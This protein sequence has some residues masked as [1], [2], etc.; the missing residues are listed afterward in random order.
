MT[1]YEPSK[2]DQ[3]TIFEV[4]AVVAFVVSRVGILSLGEIVAE[5]RRVFGEQRGL[6]T[7]S[8]VCLLSNV[9]PLL[10]PHMREALE[11]RPPYVC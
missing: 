10:P 7:S 9:Q 6:D 3:Q 1:F 5:T 2:L 8:L 4:A 11:Q